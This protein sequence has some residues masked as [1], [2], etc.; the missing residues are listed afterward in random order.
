MNTDFSVYFQKEKIVGRECTQDNTI[1]RKRKEYIDVLKGISILLVIV[2]HVN[3][4]NYMVKEYVYSIH[5]P[6]FFFSAGLVSRRHCNKKEDTISFLIQKSSNFLIPYIL[7]GLI[8][9][10][11]SISNLLYLSYGSYDSI[12][13]AGSLSSLWFFPTM[14][15]SVCMMEVFQK[16]G[17]VDSF[18]KQF[19]SI[20]L[21]VFISLLFPKIGMGYPFNINVA[22]M[23]LVFMILGY[24]LKKVA[25]KLRTK[26]VEL[27]F[28]CAGFGCGTM[29]YMLNPVEVG[30]VLMAKLEIGNI[31][32]FLIPAVSGC[33]MFLAFSIC[34]EKWGQMWIKSILVFLGRNT[35]AIFAV[36]KPIISLFE[37]IFVR[38][39][40]PQFLQLVITVAGVAVIA[41]GCAIVIKKTIPILVGNQA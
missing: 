36:H 39:S 17:F 26:K 33:L 27:L 7:W 14:F 35:I 1:N 30:Y 21:C 38:V 13:R 6:L 25:E 28:V 4:A 5:M 40:I 23:G 19:C 11:F 24:S 31:V 37:K 41:S 12:I 3:F 16:L 8:Y 10:K 15:V 32:L 20:L 18:V 9:A 2:G 34:V 29:V 22:F